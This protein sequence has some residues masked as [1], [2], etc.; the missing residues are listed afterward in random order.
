MTLYQ[1]S[2]A[3]VFK[4]WLLMTV[5]L[6]LIIG[7]G[8]LLS[9]YYGNPNLVYTAILFSLA[10]N[11]FSYFFSDKVALSLSGAQEIKSRSIHPELWNVVENLSITAGLPMPRLYLIEDPIPNAFATGRDENHSSVAVTSGLLLI[12][13][14]S[15]LE[16]VVAHEL[17]HIKNK[18]ILIQTIVVVLA[19]IIAIASDMFLRFNIFHHDD[20]KRSPLLFLLV[21]VAMIF[22]PLA[23]SIIRFSL[24]RKRE[25]LADASGAL[26]TRYPEGL[27][28][29]LQKISQY[30]QPLQQAHAATAHLYIVNP[31][32]LSERENESEEKIS[33]FSKLFM[34]HP[35]VSERIKALLDQT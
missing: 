17:S 9:L 22:A 32:G 7:L 1:H 30:R 10:L 3:N 29:A 19:G 31:L 26:L 2:A 23:A 5:F 18:D 4:T 34:T 12:L 13:N 15:E 8:L 24:S 27:A 20:E 16:G 14:K 11:F 21:L 33:W 25:F 35:P 28:K 6:V